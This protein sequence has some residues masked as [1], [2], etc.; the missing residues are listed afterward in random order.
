MVPGRH[1]AHLRVDR[2]GTFAAANAALRVHERHVVAAELGPKPP[3]DRECA[4]WRVLSKLAA[5]D[6]ATYSSWRMTKYVDD[7]RDRDDD[8]DDTRRHER[9]SKTKAHGS[10]RT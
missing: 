7:G 6:L 10:R 4:S 5:A 2:D 3:E 9:Q 1:G 8:R